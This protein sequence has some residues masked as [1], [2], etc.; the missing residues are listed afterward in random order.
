MSCFMATG[1]REDHVGSE[2]GA[3]KFWLL[4][5]DPS[6]TNTS[7]ILH[8]VS[9]NEEAHAKLRACSSADDRPYRAGYRLQA[10]DTRCRSY[11]LKF[12]RMIVGDHP[13]PEHK[14]FRC[15]GGVYLWHSYSRGLLV[16]MIQKAEKFATCS[17]CSYPLT[18]LLSQ[19][20][21]LGLWDEG[22]DRRWWLA[23]V[24]VRLLALA[25]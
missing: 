9:H 19:T 24:L 7:T 10:I 3:S 6:V 16:L 15:D 11:F 23:L 4:F 5:F 25:V 18:L 14:K 17:S 20:T 22:L 8:T 12:R 21:A 2:A 1:R 13:E